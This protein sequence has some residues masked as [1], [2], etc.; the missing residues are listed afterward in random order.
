MT[1]TTNDVINR[2]ETYRDTH[3]LGDN[4][5]LP[6]VTLF[7]KNL[8]SEVQTHI[9]DVLQLT[10]LPEG[11]RLVE[12]STASRP[13]YDGLTFQ[14]TDGTRYVGIGYYAPPTPDSVTLIVDNHGILV[15]RII[16]GQKS[17]NRYPNWVDA[18]QLLPFGHFGPNVTVRRAPIA[19]VD[20]GDTW[21]AVAYNHDGEVTEVSDNIEFRRTPISDTVMH[22]F[23]QFR[24]LADAQQYQRYYGGRLDTWDSPGIG[25]IH[26]WTDTRFSA[27]PD[28]AP[29]V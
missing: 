5:Q 26:L 6:L 22:Q 4:F 9:A 18:V 3:G 15:T 25:T 8:E 20:D 24:D 7:G 13:G 19:Y 14:A 29:A 23:V 2:I 11:Y 12:A 1:M 10:T 16:N 17:S 21:R 27:T 28:H